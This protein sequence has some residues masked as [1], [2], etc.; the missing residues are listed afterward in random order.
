VP[1]L[2]LAG[3]IYARLWGGGL[4]LV[5]ATWGVLMTGAYVHRSVYLLPYFLVAIAAS[6]TVLLRSNKGS[7][8]KPIFGVAVLVLLLVWSVGL[9]LG[10][11]TLIAWKE[12]QFR[13]P[14]LLRVMLHDKISSQPIKAYLVPYEL[15]YAA[16]EL[17]WKAWRSYGSAN[18]EDSNLCVLLSDMDVV[19]QRA[20]G[21]SQKLDSLMQEQ[22]FTRQTVAAGPSP[23]QRQENYGEY[24][25]YRRKHQESHL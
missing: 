20:D 25:V 5:A 24:L 13:N 6:M 7:R 16:R 9:S 8:L 4:A 23:A 10:A 1:L 19:V 22:G 3:I 11:R 14:D 12:R 18:W 15:Y 17:G 21:A 2:A